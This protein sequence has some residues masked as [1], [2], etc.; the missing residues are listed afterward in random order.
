MKDD[1]NQLIKIV[2]KGVD[3][4]VIVSN[5]QFRATEV[6]AV[7]IIVLCDGS[8][9]PLK[10]YRT[11]CPNNP[12]PC[13]NPFHLVEVI[14]HFTD[15]SD[16]PVRDNRI[17]YTPA[18]VMWKKFG[19]SLCGNNETNFERVDEMLI[20]PIDANEAAFDIDMCITFDSISVTN[21]NCSKCQYRKLYGIADILNA[22][23]CNSEASMSLWNEAFKRA[24]DFAYG[25]ISDFMRHYDMFPNLEEDVIRAYRNR[26]AGILTLPYEVEFD[27]IST[28]LINNGLDESAVRGIIFP[29]PLGEGAFDFRLKEPLDECIIEECRDMPAEMRKLFPGNPILFAD[30]IRGKNDDERSTLSMVLTLLERNAIFVATKKGRDT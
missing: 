30:G 15:Y 19:M 1:K 28:Y 18:G 16:A 10:V 2:A 13:Q 20:C 11:P 26:L 8:N 3:A 29:C 7:A 9:R 25:I 27:K 24:V 4:D 21:T 22:M 23:N 6:M 17:P 5:G 12:R 14:P